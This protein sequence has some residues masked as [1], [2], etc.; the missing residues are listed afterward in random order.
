MKRNAQPTIRLAKVL[1]KQGHDVT[2]RKLERWS[3]DGLGPLG[4]RDLSALARH[5]AEVSSLS[6]TGRDADT[7]AKRLCARGLP[8]V[9]LRGAILRELGLATEPPP[10]VPPMPDLS[11]EPSGDA[12]FA[13][14]EHLARAMVA[15]LR[16]LP[17]LLVKVIRALYRN[18][19]Q[20]AGELGE[21]AEEIFHS[22]VVNAL[23]HL[24]GDDYYNGEAMDAVFGLERGT[25]SPDVLH[26]LNSKLR[27]SIPT[28]DDVYRAVPVEEIALMAQR[29]TAWAPHLL[30]HLNITGVR[31]TEIEDLAAVFAPGVVHFVVLLRAAF[32]DSPS[33]FLSAPPS[34]AELAVAVPGRPFGG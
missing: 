14:L 30:R 16:G 15:D 11:S 7:V 10:V 24:V 23:A 12:A 31:K 21:P 1:V 34:V 20:R 26:V 17:P 25:V 6:T 28:L 5:Y 27:V 2:P 33:E 9:R 22:F 19:A 29:L 13:G 32:E 3:H 18:A 8:C 4:E